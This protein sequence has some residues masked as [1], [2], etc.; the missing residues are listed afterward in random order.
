MPAVG[1]RDIEP[2]VSETEPFSLLDTLKGMVDPRPAISDAYWVATHPIDRIMGRGRAANGQMAYPWGGKFPPKSFP[3]GPK[4]KGLRAVRLP[5]GPRAALPNPET[6]KTLSWNGREFFTYEGS[7]PRGIPRDQWW[8]AHLAGRM[9]NPTPRAIRGLNRQ[10]TG[11]P[12]SYNVIDKEGKIVGASHMSLFPDRTSVDQLHLNEKYRGSVEILRDMVGPALDRDL[13]IEAAPANAKLARLLNRM[14]ESGRKTVD[15]KGDTRPE[16]RVET[17]ESRRFRRGQVS[18]PRTGIFDEG[19]VDISSVPAH[20]ARFGSIAEEDA[21][22][23]RRQDIADVK[24]YDALHRMEEMGDEIWRNRRREQ[25]A[26]RR[27]PPRGTAGEIFDEGAIG[28]HNAILRRAQERRAQIHDR[29]VFSPAEAIRRTRTQERESTRAAH[30]NVSRQ[31]ELFNLVDNP[32]DLSVRA[33]NQAMR[34]QPEQFRQVMAAGTNIQRAALERQQLIE[35]A[36]LA[37]AIEANRAAEARRRALSAQLGS[38]R[39]S[40]PGGRGGV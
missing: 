35:R 31:E 24:G 2:I 34:K 11:T 8:R 3:V 27:T 9:A 17:V 16:S 32:D 19:A 20:E 1:Y 26:Q 23:T 25:L 5:V 38:N 36:R 13:P 10:E 21:Y 37:R 15:I 39:Q 7:L 29:P 33:Y 6:E 30:S 40:R 18:T 28:G 4:E 22:Y 12:V 14:K